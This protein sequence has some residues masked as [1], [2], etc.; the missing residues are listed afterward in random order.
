MLLCLLLK[1]GANVSLE[2]SSFSFYLIKSEKKC[3]HIGEE[4][5]KPPHSKETKPFWITL[6]RVLGVPAKVGVSPE[7]LVSCH[8][9]CACVKASLS[10][11]LGCTRA[12]S[13]KAAQNHAMTLVPRTGTCLYL[14]SVVTSTCIHFPDPTR[15]P[16]RLSFTSFL[17]SC[18]AW[19]PETLFLDL[20]P[21]HCQAFL[22]TWLCS[23]SSP[24]LPH[25]AD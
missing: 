4:S 5:W 22:G 21:A 2:R 11:A 23:W 17:S 25:S 3:W 14:A 18:L 10:W 12:E 13:L 9:P 15:C 1:P 8:P 16:S 6:G 7:T 19:C 20:L 24:V